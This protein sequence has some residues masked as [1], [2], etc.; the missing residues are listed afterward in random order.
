MQRCYF[1]SSSEPDSDPAIATY[2]IRVR[3]DFFFPTSTYSKSAAIRTIKVV[4]QASSSESESDSMVRCVMF[5]AL[6]GVLLAARAS[7]AAD[8]P[9]TFRCSGG[10]AAAAAAAPAEAAAAGA[11]AAAAAEAGFCRCCCTRATCVCCG[12]AG[13]AS[14][15]MLSSA[16]PS[17]EESIKIASAIDAPGVHGNARVVIKLAFRLLPAVFGAVCCASC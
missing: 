12:A 2:S 8:A 4:F 3:A 10:K 15:A 16:P 9:A 6:R 13:A 17:S 1:N 14:A 7:A 5:D 11:G